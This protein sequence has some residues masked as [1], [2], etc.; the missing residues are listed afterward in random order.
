MVELMV[1][2]TIGLLIVSAAAMLTSTQ[3]TENR[4]L[5]LETQLQQDLR[6]ST[7]IITRE[8]RR[9]SYWPD[10]HQ[11]IWYP[12]KAT[13]T[14]ENTFGP[15]SAASDAFLTEFEFKYRRRSGDE[16]PY[17]FKKDGNLLRTRFAGSWHALTDSRV[18]TIQDFR[19]LLSTPEV[20][21]L[22]CPKTCPL[23]GGPQDCWPSLQVRTATISVT[24]K[25]VADPSLVRT[26][27]TRARIR[28]D[29]VKFNG[30]SVCPA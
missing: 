9:A 16:G 24:G 7:D 14:A 6:A 13:A 4:R 27:T 25:S 26:L 23:P 15:M 29:F 1:G 18:M 12:D 19:V 30:A 2:V 10:S 20:F 11:Q 17:G 3:L 28:N 8:L 5:L 21:Q 22:P